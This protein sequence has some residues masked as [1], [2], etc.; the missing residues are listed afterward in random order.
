[1]IS[2]EHRCVFIHQRKCAGSSIME[3]FGITRLD[4]PRRHYAND[5]VLSPEFHAR[6]ANYL[7]LSVVRNPWERLVSG[8]LHCEATRPTPLHELLRH[9]PSSG[10][11]Y[12]H[13]TRLQRDILHDGSGHLVT[14]Q[15]MRFETL[16]A[17]FDRACRSIGK[18]VAT[19]P[20]INQ[21]SHLPYRAYFE[22]AIDRD[23]FLRHFAR[24]VDA[25]GHE[26]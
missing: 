23:L 18:T 25:F 11:E 16:Q 26:F 12:R 6:P 2:H 10:M 5:G 1:M 15:L 20:R 14:D 3:S 9:L 8:W 13:I 21:T 7:V 4:D 22:H 17:D 19:L 24:D